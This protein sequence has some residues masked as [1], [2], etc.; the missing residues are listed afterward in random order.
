[1]VVN[2][3][4][5]KKVSGKVTKPKPIPRHRP[6]PNP[7]GTNGPVKSRVKAKKRVATTRAK[8]TSKRR[9]GSSG[10]LDQSKSRS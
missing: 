1:M 8:P 7:S 6:R 3:R 4:K 9:L 2:K 5:P 10:L